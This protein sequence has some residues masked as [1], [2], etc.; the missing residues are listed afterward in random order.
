MG[1]VQLLLTG[2]LNG[3]AYAVVALAF[4]LIYRSSGI[5]NFAQGALVMLGGYTVWTFTA[6]WGNPW[7]ALGVAVIVSFLF[8][9]VLERVILRPM[10]GQPV[11]SMVMATLGLMVLLEGL[12]LLL[13]GGAPK[14]F[15][16][17]L[18]GPALA[19]GPIPVNRSLLVGGLVSLGLIVL[20]WQFFERTV[21]GL[22]MT[23]VAESHVVAQSLG[24]SP[25]SAIALSWG[26][27]MA[28]STWGAVV[29]MDGRNL[30]PL[31]AHI[32]LKVLVLPLLS[33]LESIPGVILSGLLV[34][35]GEAAASA[36]LDPLT[37]GGMST[38][39]PYILILVALLLR[40]QGFFGWKVIER[41]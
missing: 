26:A 19:V 25:Q 17:F 21:P 28:L 32:G 13:W 18:A 22:R 2:A 7:V 40:P 15:P 1:L 31:V 30:T 4:V 38:M 20:V 27:A 6:R 41:V 33:G 14:P 35:I 8:G 3:L 11:F 37:D 23:A 5:F 9:L 12:V 24:I 29:L 10:V 39:F 16:R 36:Y 34:G